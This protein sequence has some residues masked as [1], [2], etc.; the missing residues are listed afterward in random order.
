MHEHERCRND[1]E[2][3]SAVEDRREKRQDNSG[4]S[5]NNIWWDGVKL[6]LNDF[7][8]R[9]DSG[10]DSGSEEGQALHGNIVEQEDEGG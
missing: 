5:S 2:E 8:I 10:H 7:S 9:V 1:H 6:E 3:Q 4:K